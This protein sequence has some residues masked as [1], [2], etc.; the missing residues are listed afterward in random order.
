M[1]HLAVKADRVFQKQALCWDGQHF[2]TVP[3]KV[4]FL[5]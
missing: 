1:S 3:L 2:Y 5:H 4:L